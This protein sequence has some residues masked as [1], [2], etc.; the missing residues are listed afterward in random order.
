MLLPAD[1]GTV[2]QYSGAYSKSQ[3]FAVNVYPH[4]PRAFVIDLP[5]G[6]PPVVSANAT[7]AGSVHALS[8]PCITNQHPST[9]IPP[10]LGPDF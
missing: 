3:V 2:V 6:R 9:R 7:F 1:F 5:V 4:P 10:P 8:A